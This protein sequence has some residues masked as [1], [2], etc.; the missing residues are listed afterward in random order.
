MP[1]LALLLAL[2]GAAHA[3]HK[4]DLHRVVTAYDVVRVQHSFP[5]ST[6]ETLAPG[7][8]HRTVFVAHNRTFALSMV[9]NT[10]LFAPDVSFEVHG[11]GVAHR[12]DLDTTRFLVGKVEGYDDSLVH[13]MIHEDL[14]IDGHISVDGEHFIV[15]PAHRYFDGRD[16]HTL[17][18]KASSLHI[19]ASEYGQYCGHGAKTSTAG[20]RATRSEDLHE[21]GVSVTT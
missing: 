4:P 17:V 12:V 21:P 7:A 1:L 8:R 2:V 18:F 15:E 19:N 16:G 5:G 3:L 6:R 11:D 14:S 20:K 9:H 10:A 13:V